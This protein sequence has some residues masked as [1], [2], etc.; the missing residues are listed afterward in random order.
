MIKW[1]EN[2]FVSKRLRA[3]EH[4]IK[5]LETELEKCKAQLLELEDWFIPEIPEEVLDAAYSS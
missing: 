4:R 5:E 2:L 3:A 1:I